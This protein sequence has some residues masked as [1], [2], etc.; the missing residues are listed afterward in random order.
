MQ[1]IKKKKQKLVIAFSIDT[2]ILQQPSHGKYIQPIASL[3][4]I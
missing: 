2:L 4:L 1:L 3:Q